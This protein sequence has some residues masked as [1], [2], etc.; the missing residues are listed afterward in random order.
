MKV[1]IFTIPKAGTY[2][3]ANLLENLGYKDTG[4]HISR[5]TRL[6]TRKFDLETNARTPSI[7][8]ERI[9]FFD[10]MTQMRD[11]EVAF[12]H[13]PAPLM[14]WLFPPFRFICSYRHPRKTLVSEF[15]DFRFRRADVLWLKPTAI[16]DDA[17]A[18][19]AYLQRRGERRAEMLEKILQVRMLAAGGDLDGFTPDRVCF[20]NFDE[21]LTDPLKLEPLRDLLQLGPEIDLRQAHAK[22]LDS[23][24]KTKATG[25]V[26]DRDALWTPAAD[27]LYRSMKF[28]R[29][30]DRMQAQGLTF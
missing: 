14:S 10:T 20:V 18:F 15:I 21:V 23:E 19:T 30:V 4:F 28:E 6:N 11:R 13:F 22:S 7:A 25:M 29:T 26:F 16:V 2:F 5:N 17:K 9:N 3:L 27:A 8:I 24:T 12:G 1:F